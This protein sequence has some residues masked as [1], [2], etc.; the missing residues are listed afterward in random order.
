MSVKKLLVLAAA[1]IAAVSATSVFAGGPDHVAMP[2]APAFE[3]QIY[4]EGH[5][6]YAEQDWRALGPVNVFGSFGGNSRGGFTAGGDVGYQF[7]RNWAIEFG[8]FYLPRV[9]G[10]ANGI[11]GVAGTG[12]RITSWFIYLASKLTVP[13]FDHFDIY[14]KAGGAYR[15]LRYRG[16][17]VP[18]N[19]GQWAPYFAAGAQYLITDNWTASIQYTNI[20][21]LIRSAN[22][23]R[24][25]P[26][27][28]LYTFALGYQFAV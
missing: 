4:V 13:L 28:N 11:V 2:A 17:L 9:R 26:T 15:Q 19:V 14:G 22:P 27:A 23:A 6:G 1:G 21:A 3:P 18:G 24:N 10:T 16:N 12:L 25:A 7:V 5:V 20:P 8:G